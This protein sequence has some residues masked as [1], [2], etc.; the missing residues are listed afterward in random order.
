MSLS[1]EDTAA[2]GSKSTGVVLG[3]INS[4]LSVSRSRYDSPK[5]SP[6]KIT[7]ESTSDMQ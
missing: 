6:E 3:K 4:P 2:S 5:V 7:P 1:T